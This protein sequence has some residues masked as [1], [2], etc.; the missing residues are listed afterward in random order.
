MKWV[1][2]LLVAVLCVVAVTVVSCSKPAEEE[3]GPVVAPPRPTP[4]P[5][6]ESEEESEVATEPGDPMD[7]VKVIG[8]D[9]PEGATAKGCEPS[10]DGVKAT[11]ETEMPFEEVKAY[12]TEKCADW[13][14]NGLEGGAMAGNDWEF[15]SPDGKMTIQITSES[16]EGPT[17]IEY[18]VQCE[19]GE[20]ED[21]LATSESA[22]ESAV[23]P[24]EG[25][26][27]APVE[28]DVTD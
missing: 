16:M 8:V 15:K 17:T 27:A 3:Q 23:E 25:E 12:F 28:V 20:F 26:A 24:A 18:T 19:P 7:V 2:L 1:S 10:E 4:P 6:A 14:N 22:T 13:E 9:L 5:P 11:F 21:L